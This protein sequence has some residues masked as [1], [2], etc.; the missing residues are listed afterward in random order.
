MLAITTGTGSGIN[1]T[2]LCGGGPATL[3]GPRD[4][5]QTRGPVGYL[6]DFL[7]DAKVTRIIDGLSVTPGGDQFVFAQ[8]TQMLR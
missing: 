6:G 5:C 7:N 3:L 1:V 2:N 8:L 4:C